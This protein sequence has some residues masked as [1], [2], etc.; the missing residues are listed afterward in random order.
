MKPNRIVPLRW[1]AHATRRVIGP[2]AGLRCVRGRLK[3]S[4][5]AAY[6]IVVF[7]V[8]VSVCSILAQAASHRDEPAQIHLTKADKKWVT[9]TLRSL[10]LEEKI[11][12]MLMGRCFLDYSGFDSP[13]YKELRDDL[14]KHHIGSLVIAA[15]I[16]RQGLVRPSPL[17]A[18]KVA[19]Q[20]QADS[21]LPLLNTR[22]CVS[23]I[24]KI[25]MW[26]TSFNRSKARRPPAQFRLAIPVNLSYNPLTRG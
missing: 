21:K 13:D 4:R 7:A 8:S 10:S 6:A 18:A 25:H 16:N 26:W 3:P 17:E 22:A 11:G 1:T 24:R 9:A 5:T 19:N 14:Q 2:P 12:Q 23:P 15:H 20:L